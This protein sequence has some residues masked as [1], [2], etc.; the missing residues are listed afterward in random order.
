MQGQGRRV[1]IRLADQLFQNQE[2]L[3]ILALLLIGAGQPQLNLGEI[4]P[5][6]GFMP[7]GLGSFLLGFCGFSQA[8]QHLRHM[9]AQGDI[10]GRNLE[11]LPQG[12]NLVS[13]REHGDRS[14]EG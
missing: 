13:V 10:L 8:Q 11:G 2:G 9:E 1:G 6:F 7:Q 14:G 3:G 12:F 5:C 4:C